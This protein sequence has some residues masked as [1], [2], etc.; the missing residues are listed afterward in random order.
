MLFKPAFWVVVEIFLMIFE[1]NKSF[2]FFH[3]LNPNRKFI[4]DMVKF[5][6]YFRNVFLR[7]MFKCFCN[8]VV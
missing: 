3:A 7:S 6:V 1:G 4:C 2:A 5:V 8:I